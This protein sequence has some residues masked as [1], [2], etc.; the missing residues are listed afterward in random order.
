MI[1]MMKANRSVLWLFQ[2][3]DLM[4][5]EECVN[6]LQTFNAEKIPSIPVDIRLKHSQYTMEK[7]KGRTW[8][9]YN[10]L[11]NSM[12]TM[13]DREYKQYREQNFSYLVHHLSGVHYEPVGDQIV[14]DREQNYGEHALCLKPR[15]LHYG[16]PCR[17]AH[18]RHHVQRPYDEYCQCGKEGPEFRRDPLCYFQEGSVALNKCQITEIREEHSRER[19]SC[20]YRPE[21]C[22][23]I[24]APLYGKEHARRTEVH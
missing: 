18:S 21:C 2:R 20:E 12:L 19:Y 13:S 9:L 6:Y 7:H 23:C 17:G 15:D 4:T 14:N 3:K 5:A 10:T 24:L 16:R 1:L 8:I 22:A 11:Y